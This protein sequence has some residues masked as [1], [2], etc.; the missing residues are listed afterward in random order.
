[1]YAPTLKAPD[2]DSLE[3]TI[4]YL[5]HVGGFI[6]VWDFA[7]PNCQ[8]CD[9]ADLSSPAV[10]DAYVRSFTA[11]DGFTFQGVTVQNSADFA[12]VYHAYIFNYG[13]NGYDEVAREA[14]TMSAGSGWDMFEY[15]MGP[16]GSLCVATP[17]PVYSLE[18][19][20]LRAG[21]WYP[22]DSTN[23]VTWLVGDDGCFNGP[24]QPIYYANGT[25][26]TNSSWVVYTGT[27]RVGTT[28][29]QLPGAALDVAIGRHNDLWV[30]GSDNN[31]YSWNGS[32][33]VQYPGIAGTRVASDLDGN[34]WVVNAAG[35]IFTH[36]GGTWQQ[37]TG[38]ALDVGANAGAVWVI[39]CDHGVY[40]WNGAYTGNTFAR[41]AG[42]GIRIT[43]DAAGNPWFVDANGSI[44]FEKQGVVQQ[45]QGCALDVG[46]NTNGL[47][48]IGCS[49]GIYYWTG[50]L[51]GNT[52]TQVSGGGTNIAVSTYGLPVVSN[53]ALGIYQRI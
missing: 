31:L 2:P 46:A 11:P 52:F 42:S 41:A 49:Q 28:W 37:V 26:G 25:F 17:G 6:G 24:D 14:A 22:L 4:V 1:L 3:I 50:A 20:E 53:S 34:P 48:V 32:S 35:N 36:R 45:V 15:Y 30:I 38:C 40:S 21:T 18:I 43:V 44:F 12:G 33:F 16:P 29:Q 23:S 47:W 51:T 8:F 19:N 13:A 10:Q 39:G 9:V 27:Q 5:P 7:D